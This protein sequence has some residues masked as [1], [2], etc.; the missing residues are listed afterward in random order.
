M[1][2]MLWSRTLVPAC[3]QLQDA[4]FDVAIVAVL[5]PVASAALEV[6]R[7][8]V[9]HGA[10]R[11]TRPRTVLEHRRQLEVDALWDKIFNEK[12]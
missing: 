12:N 8:E 5:V 10:R 7:H 6:H 3:I 9:A 11:Q 1:F 4:G 2:I